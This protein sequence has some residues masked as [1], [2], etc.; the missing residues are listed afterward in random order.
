MPK[1]EILF[2][3]LVVTDFLRIM[4]NYPIVKR[5]LL[6]LHRPQ[7]I[8]K[9]HELL[10]KKLT[11]KITENKIRIIVRQIQMLNTIIN[12]QREAPSVHTAPLL[13][14]DP[15]YVLAFNLSKAIMAKTS[16]NCLMTKTQVCLPSEISVCKRLCS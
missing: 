3:L 7:L 9:R 15:L 8:Q 11:S 6:W 1:I 13:Y 10:R 14:Q 4:L 2:L 16:D 5:I 12:Y